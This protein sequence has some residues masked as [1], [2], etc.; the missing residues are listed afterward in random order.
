[1]KPSRSRALAVCSVPVLAGAFLVSSGS[2][3]S[4]E[5]ATDIP[6]TVTA[7]AYT[8]GSDIVSLPANVDADQSPALVCRALDP[9]DSYLVGFQG[10]LDM[11]NVWSNYADMAA[12]GRATNPGAFNRLVITGEWTTSMTVDT[13][14]VDIDVSAYTVEAV[15]AQFEKANAASGAAFAKAMRVQ[16]ASVVNGTFSATYRLM[17]QDASGAWVD[18]ITAADLENASMR[19]DKVYFPSLEGSLSVSQARMNASA[20]SSIQ[21]TSPSVTGSLDIPALARI[22]FISGVRPI[23]FTNGVG[24]PVTIE[25]R[26]QPAVTVKYS[27]DDAAY[28][29]PRE[30]TDME[31]STEGAI[32]SSPVTELPRPAR[33]VVDTSDIEWNWKGR[34]GMSV[35][36]SACGGVT[37]NSTW[38]PTVKQSPAPAPST[39]ASVPA[40][41]APAAAAV[42][43]P[44]KP[45]ARTGATDLVLPLSALLS[46]AG[47]ATV[48][49]TRRRA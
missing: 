3:N 37:F 20:T 14:D 15:Q 23:N 40:S 12:I 16:S 31:S 42:N 21:A 17:H 39:S 1:M 25:L 43:N 48:A 38:A 6:I 11:T 5:A 35:K 41:T 9:K 46:A 18:G 13:N 8:P 22:P 28:A 24:A 2:F 29:L 7:E 32:A 33:T 19:P 27:S 49:A 36:Q 34:T 45:L 44:K 10:I 47:I 26:Q 30:I 4:S